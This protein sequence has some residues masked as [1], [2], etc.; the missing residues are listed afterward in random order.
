MKIDS[1][2]LDSK[3]YNCCRECGKH[4]LTLPENK[5]KKQFDISTYQ[6]GM[7][8]RVTSAMRRDL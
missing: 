8:E 3:I 7:L 6:H 4:A 5:G 1:N 2:K